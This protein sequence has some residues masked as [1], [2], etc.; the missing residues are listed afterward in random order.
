MLFEISES[1]QYIMLSRYV[2]ESKILWQQRPFPTTGYPLPG[3]NVTNVIH[4]R[5]NMK[6][7]PD[8]T[9][10]PGNVLRI[11]YKKNSVSGKKNNIGGVR[12]LARPFPPQ[13]SCTLTYEIYFAPNFHFVLGGKLP[14]LYGGRG[15]CSG[16][17]SSMCYS[18]RFMWRRNGAGEIYLYSPM[19]QA[20]DFC[21]RPEVHCNFDY[22]HSLGRRSFHFTKGKWIKIQQYIRMNAPGRRDGIARVWVD[23]RLVLSM[24]DINYRGTTSVM[25]NAIYFSTFFGGSSSRWASAVDT[26]TYYK[27]FEIWDHQPSFRIE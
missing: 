23:G 16:G 12:F 24:T 14:G 21:S 18:T 4:R 5:H 17:R 7:V 19:T 1:R 15:T 10:A 20:S 26:F 3:W 22:G 13:N 11:A 2:V 27:K 6:V 8:P 9:G 25:A